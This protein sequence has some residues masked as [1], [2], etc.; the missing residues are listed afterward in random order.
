MSSV[1]IAAERPRVLVLGRAPPRAVQAIAQFA[2][3]LSVATPA[4]ARQAGAGCRGLAVWGGAVDRTLIEALGRLE[5]IAGFGVGYDNI[6]VGAA[7]ARGVVVTHTPDVLTEQVADVTLGLLLMTVLRLPQAERHVRAGL[8]PRGAFPLSPTSLRGRRV[9]ILGLGRIGKAVARRLEAFDLPVAYYGRAPQADVAYP[10]FESPLALAGAVDT[11]I[12]ILPGGAQTH[13]LIDRAVLRALGPDG[14]FVNVGRG[15][16]V[17][18]AALIEALAA[19]E[20]AAAGLDV[21]EREPQVPQPLLAFD[22]VVVLPHVGSATVLTRNAMMDL[23]ARN[24]KAW[25]ET[26]AA[27]TP[28]PETAHLATR[29]G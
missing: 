17:D 28:T 14:V 13:H 16:S 3:V 4:E 2:D 15:S 20:I 21:F 12:A 24:L 23:V 5:I 22:N 18:E 9:G 11:L 8:W 6:D 10:Y 19:R 29:K 7:A 25:F 26:G 27:V 1:D